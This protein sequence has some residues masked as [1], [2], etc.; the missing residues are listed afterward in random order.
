MLF[1]RQII[2]N[3]FWNQTPLARITLAVGAALTLN[4]FFGC[5]F[6]LTEKGVQ[7]SLTFWDSIWWAMVTMTTVGYGDFY[8]QTWVGR[9]LITYPCFLFGIGLIGL[10]LGTMIDALADLLNRKKRG[11]LSI[12]MKKHVIISGCPS[13]PR[14][15]K[16]VTELYQTQQHTAPPVVIVSEKLKELPLAFSKLNM[17]FI[18]GSLRNKEVLERSSV[19]EAQGVII[20][21]ESESID[22]DTEVYA[23]ASFIKNTLPDSS[24]HILSLINKEESVELFENAKLQYVRNDGMPDNIMAQE[25]RQPGAASIFRQLMTYSSG[26]EVYIR[27]HQHNGQSIQALQMKALET[28]LTI[29]IIGVIR[30]DVHNL[31]PE[32]DYTLTEQ[33][34]LIFLAKNNSDC[35]SFFAQYSS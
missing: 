11:L 4:I 14:V 13:I 10:L 3:L 2:R 30:G 22:P 28:P 32:K 7:E 20:L 9:F 19:K 1:F 18:Q 27:E 8:P 25:F 15:T 24:L 6:Y 5:A 31:N 17:T 23:T 16:I 33:D 21:P 29:Q 35:D 12:K 26:C 34:R